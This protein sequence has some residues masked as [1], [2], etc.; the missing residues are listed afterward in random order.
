M[1][2]TTDHLLSM[3]QS[4]NFYEAILA[5]DH[6]AYIG[7]LRLALQSAKAGTDLGIVKLTIVTVT[8]L[9][10]NIYTCKQRQ[11]SVSVIS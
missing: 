2:S 5:H 9:A 8:F 3:Q 7:V 6:P 10:L 4:L 1:A 11:S